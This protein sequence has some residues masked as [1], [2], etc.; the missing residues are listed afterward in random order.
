LETIEGTAAVKPCM[1]STYDTSF[2]I[3]P[4]R[5]A[6]SSDSKVLVHCMVSS[7]PEVA[8]VV[9]TDGAFPG[10][11]RFQWSE[12]LGFMRAHH[13]RTVQWVTHSFP[14]WNASGGADHLLW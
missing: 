10:M 14:F 11:H 13:L 2:C 7:A 6:H 8:E 5:H 9:T 1:T 4:L 12:N 3:G